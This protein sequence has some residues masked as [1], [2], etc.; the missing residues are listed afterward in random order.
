MISEKISK[1][2]ARPCLS[3]YNEVQK[4][5]MCMSCFMLSIILQ[6]R[7]DYFIITFV[8]YPEAL[9]TMGTSN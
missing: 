7:A 2:T 8:I 9:K 1:P 5:Y 4:Q 3:L 6:T